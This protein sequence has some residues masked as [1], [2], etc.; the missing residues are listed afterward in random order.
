MQNTFALKVSASC[1]QEHEDETPS[2]LSA[3]MLYSPAIIAHE[4]DWNLDEVHWTERSKCDNFCNL[5][6]V[7][8]GIVVAA[9][10]KQSE[11]WGTLR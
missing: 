9:G 1:T 7:M 4:I 5:P 10:A 11:G 8:L 2:A 6:L 3:T